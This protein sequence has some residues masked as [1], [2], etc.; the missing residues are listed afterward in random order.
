MTWRAISAR[1]C[2]QEPAGRRDGERGSGGGGGGRAAAKARDPWRRPAAAAADDSGARGVN[3]GAILTSVLAGLGAAACY[4][5]YSVVANVNPAVDGQS[6]SS[7]VSATAGHDYEAEYKLPELLQRVG[8]AI[9]SFTRSTHLPA[10]I[11]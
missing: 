8:P 5:A 9:M 7:Y 3:S 10:L 2:V 4:A 6:Q 1:P 11:S